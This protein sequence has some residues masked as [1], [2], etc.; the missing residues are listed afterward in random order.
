[1]L[2][3]GGKLHDLVDDALL[4][5]D[6]GADLLVRNVA[7]ALRGKPEEFREPVLE[8][9]AETMNTTRKAVA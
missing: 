6:V 2:G 1:M 3:P 9:L 5:G 4:Y 8:F 7:H